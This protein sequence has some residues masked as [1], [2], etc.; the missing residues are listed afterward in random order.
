GLAGFSKLIVIKSIRQDLEH[1]PRLRE[2]LINEAR[3]AARLQHPNVVQTLEVG[4]H[5]GKVYLAME[6]LDGQP[7][8]RVIRRARDTLE[9]PLAAAIV[10]ELLSG[11]HCAHDLLDYDGRPLRIVHRDVSPQNVFLTYEGEVKIVDFGIAKAA[12]ESEHTEAGIIKGKV[13]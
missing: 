1:E 6:F 8:S 13:A 10:M 2:A 11:L 12:I 7:L 3:L 5:R 9:V 4:E